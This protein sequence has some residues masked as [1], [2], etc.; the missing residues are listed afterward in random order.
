[1]SDIPRNGSPNP[2]GKPALTYRI[3]DRASFL[4]AMLDLLPREQIPSGPNASAVPLQALT[5]RAP[6]DWTIA[7]L[8]AWAGIG[9]ILTF[10]QERIANEGYIG[11]AMERL[12]AVELAG[13]VGYQPRPG[14]SAAADLAFTVADDDGSARSIS[15][16][17]GL[18]VQSVPDPGQ[19]PQTFE[20]V[21]A[22]HLSSAWN[23][24]RPLLTQ[25]QRIDPGCRRLYLDSTQ[26]G[27]STGDYILFLDT[28]TLDTSAP[29]WWLRQLDSVE[30]ETTAEGIERTLVTWREPL[31]RLPDTSAVS[32]YALR[33][34]APLFGYNA[35]DWPTLPYDAKQSAVPPG[36]APQD[37]SEWPGFDID[38]GK[39]DLDAI[40][41]TVLAGSYLVLMQPTALTLAQVGMARTVSENAFSMSAQVTQIVAESLAQISYHRALSPPR[42]DLTA[43]LLPGGKVLLAGGRAASGASA[44]IEIY[45]PATR[46]IETVGTLLTPRWNHTAILLPDQTI[47]I[48]GGENETGVLASAE[49]LAITGST[50]YTT[51]TLPPMSVARTSHRATALPNGPVLISG[52]YDGTSSL[53]SAELYQPKTR[54][55]DPPI[56]LTTARRRHSATLVVLQGDVRVLLA[57]GDDNGVALDSAESYVAATNSSTAITS[58]MTAARTEHRAIYLPGA[59]TVL[60]TGGASAPGGPASSPSAE[61]FSPLRDPAGGRFQ[62]TGA[63]LTP[64]WQH[65]A[66]LLQTGDVLV[67]GGTDTGTTALAAVELYSPGTGSFRAAVPA[68]LAR[69][70]GTATLLPNGTVLLAGGSDGATPLTDL[71]TYD[72]TVE[73]FVATGAMPVFS[74]GGAGALLPNGYGL[75]TGGFGMTVQTPPPFSPPPDGPLGNALLYNPF[76]GLFTETGAM[77]TARAY[78]TATTLDNGSILAAGGQ[79]MQ[80]NPELRQIITMLQ[81]LT[82]VVNQ[83]IPLTNDIIAQANAGNTALTYVISGAQNSPYTGNITV[84]FGGFIYNIHGNWTHQ[85]NYTITLTCDGKPPKGHDDDSPWVWQWDTTLWNLMAPVQYLIDW[86]TADFNRILQDAS[87]GSGATLESVTQQVLEGIQNIIDAIYAMGPGLLTAEVYDPTTGAFAQ[88]NEP[89]LQSRYFHSASLLPTGQ[90]LLCGG[91]PFDLKRPGPFLPL[92]SAELYDPGASSFTATSSP[93]ITPR[94]QHTATVLVNGLVL[95]AGGSDGQHSLANA[96]IYDPASDQFT[97]TGS[98]SFARRGHTATL[99][100]DG[101]VLIAGGVDSKNRPV[102]TCEIFYPAWGGFGLTAQLSPA[103]AFHVSS[104]LDDGRVLIA[105]GTSGTAALTTAFLYDPLNGTATPTG[106]MSAGQVLAVALRLPTGRILVAGGSSDGYGQD[107][108]NTATLYVAPPQPLPDGGR[109]NSTVL[110]QSQAL[111]LAL[112]PLTLPVLDDQLILGHADTSL[113]AGQVVILSGRP[114]Q[115][116]VLPASAGLRLT[117]PASGRWV[118]LQDGEALGIV[119]V[120]LP[121]AGNNRVWMLSTAKGFTGTLLAP[122]DVF[123]LEPDAAAPMGAERLVIAAAETPVSGGPTRLVFTSPL[124]RIYERV[125]IS[126]NANIVS[127][128]QTQTIADEILGSGDGAIP[129]Q[130]FPLT[131]YPLSSFP[132]ATAKGNRN[133]VTVTVD[134]VEWRGVDSM[135]DSLPS[136]QVYTLRRDRNGRATVSF[137]DGRHGAR[138][139][140]GSDNVIATYGIGIGTNGNVPADRLQQMLQPPQYAETVTNPL[141]ARSGTAADTRDILRRIAPVTTLSLG[142]IVGLMDFETFA[143]DFAGI[144]KAQAT[145]LPPPGGRRV[146]LVVAGQDG[147][148]VTPGSALHAR[149]SDAIAAASDPGLSCILVSCT[150]RLFALAARL[151]I[152]PRH[153]A[154]SVIAA[155]RLLLLERFGFIARNFGQGLAASAVITALQ[156]VPGVDGVE[157]TEFDFGADPPE[158]HSWLPAAGVSVED[159]RITP[160]ELLTI[161]PARIALSVE[162]SS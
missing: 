86:T 149:L 67:T 97:A 32:V 22:A 6:E 56:A 13:L 66:V 34:S 154:D 28:S 16:D 109:R 140:S 25:P 144:A 64:R 88:T 42:T 24:I 151:A 130:S 134:G 124:Q 48:A 5:T 57:G 70:Q 60:L 99:L 161:D 3:G 79:L 108:V 78:H 118:A 75:Y 98:L 14:L 142:R 50:P 143:L 83:F 74:I 102:A 122:L 93:M 110:T 106:D 159:G 89:M 120:S 116:I 105:G 71:E 46:A 82:T 103:P 1:M 146:C 135:I 94:L 126:I 77:G 119:S 51:Q 69:Q 117:D 7:L 131:E 127:A 31:D 112:D 12:S 43:T 9:D 141:P 145:A 38:P 80:L 147:A 101:R 100:P 62:A 91:E 30:P 162:P 65:E 84:N 63:M 72:P 85:G 155:A 113:T 95:I 153:D 115:L 17:P 36:Y 150:P 133:A 129:H 138:L 152:D 125:T 55:F 54:Q 39:L 137:G 139:P 157:L 53:A 11:T 27:L 45:D 18:A 37:F 19:L 111:P 49:L 73:T 2:P 23:A 26:T 10:Y 35:P 90:V 4:Q 92:G 160:P 81:D 76:T 114:M 136:D 128:L 107:P 58:K 40:Y 8:H 21:T 123:R 44:A 121:D 52:G 33:L 87:T 96:E 148:A 41:P 104:L 132:A 61:L 47:L 20:T 68:A 29:A 156:T 15:L 158:R 59:G